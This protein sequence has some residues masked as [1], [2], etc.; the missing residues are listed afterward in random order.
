MSADTHQATL[1]IEALRTY[2]AKAMLDY[3][4]GDHAVPPDAAIVDLIDTYEWLLERREH[5]AIDHDALKRENAKLRD[6]AMSLRDK[7]SE[8]EH[9]NVLLTDERNS[10]RNAQP[11]TIVGTGHGPA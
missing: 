6:Q 8:I 3:A 2:L 9:E 7:V 4:P 1:A 5:L 10:L 11:C